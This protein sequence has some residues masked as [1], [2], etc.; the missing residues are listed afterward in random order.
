MR[1]KYSWVKDSHF[2]PKELAMGIKD[3]MEHVYKKSEAKAIAKGHLMQHKRY[4]T[5]LR[6]ARL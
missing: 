6:R 3:E 4:Y 5:K 1:I 2:D